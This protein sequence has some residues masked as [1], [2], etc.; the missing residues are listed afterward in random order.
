MQRI[1]SCL[2]LSEVLCGRGRR[3]KGR[4]EGLWPERGTLDVEAMSFLIL[5][6]PQNR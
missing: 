3:F 2:G 5:F 4:G 6:L 1:M